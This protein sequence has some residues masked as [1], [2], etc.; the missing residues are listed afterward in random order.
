MVLHDLELLRLEELLSNIVFFEQRVYGFDTSL[1]PCTAKLNIRLSAVSSLLIE[2][3]E[4]PATCRRPTKARMSAV[5]IVDMR[6]PPKNG[7]RWVSTRYSIVVSD[8][9]PFVR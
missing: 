1:P 9:F 5:P 8:R 4:A 7:F 2:P 6:R 3:F